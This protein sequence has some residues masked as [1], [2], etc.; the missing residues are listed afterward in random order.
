MSPNT[1]PSP[2]DLKRAAGSEFAN[3]PSGQWCNELECYGVGEDFTWGFRVYR[4]VYT[5]DSD[6]GEC[7]TFNDDDWALA[8]WAFMQ[9]H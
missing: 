1:L 5:P 7:N 6:R 8:S 3:R 2:A 9:A 4:T